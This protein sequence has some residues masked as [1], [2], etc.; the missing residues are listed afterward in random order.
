MKALVKFILLSITG[1]AGVKVIEEN[2]VAGTIFFLI[3]LGATYSMLLE[4]HIIDSDTV[5]KI[6]KIT[7]GIIAYIITAIIDGILS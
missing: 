2:K 1:G 6:L 5:P 7:I 4:L 3:S